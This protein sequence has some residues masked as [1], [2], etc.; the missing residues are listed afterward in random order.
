MYWILSKSIQPFKCEEVSNAHTHTYTDLAFILV[1]YSIWYHNKEIIENKLKVYLICFKIWIQKYVWKQLYLIFNFFQ[2]TLR[3][4]DLPGQERLRNKYF[5]QYKSSAKA[6]VYV[7]DSVTIQK[8]IRDVA[9]WVF[10]QHV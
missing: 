8:E 6:I 2:K 5:D 4:V 3:L 9:E 7:V 10:M 1:N